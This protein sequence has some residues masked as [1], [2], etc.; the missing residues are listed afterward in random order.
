M[1]VQSKSMK[2]SSGWL[3]VF[4]NPVSRKNPIRKQRRRVG[5]GGFLDNY[6]KLTIFKYQNA[7]TSSGDKKYHPGCNN[8][9]IYSSLASSRERSTRSEFDGKTC[10]T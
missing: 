2:W 6:S 8:T 9:P 5:G 10:M 4:L 3:E 7:F 1:S